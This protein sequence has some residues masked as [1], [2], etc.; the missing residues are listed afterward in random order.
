MSEGGREEG[1]EEGR[2]NGRK[3][4]RSVPPTSAHHKTCVLTLPGRH[5]N[6]MKD[7]ARSETGCGS[8]TIFKTRVYV[9]NEC[10]KRKQCSGTR[11][12]QRG[13]DSRSSV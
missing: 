12:D 6:V 13:K 8:G 7:V 5:T 2:E 1:R 9:T 3:R 11:R 4:V 10:K